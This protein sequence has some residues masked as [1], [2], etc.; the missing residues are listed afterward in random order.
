M[1]SAEGA[2]K[3]RLTL[4]GLRMQDED[5]SL[6]RFRNMKEAKHRGGGKPWFEVR[7]D[8]QFSVSK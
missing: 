2:R 6:E 1:E 5:S 7:S 8:I 3:K 4:E